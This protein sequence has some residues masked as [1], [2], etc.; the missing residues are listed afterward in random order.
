[1][2]YQNTEA[3]EKRLNATNM[4]KCQLRFKKSIV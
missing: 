4:Q 1:M 2:T 3:K